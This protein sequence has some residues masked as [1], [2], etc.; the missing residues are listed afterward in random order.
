MPPKGCGKRIADE[1]SRIADA[2]A[3]AARARAGTKIGFAETLRALHESGAL[4]EGMPRRSVRQ[5]RRDVQTITEAHAKAI[6]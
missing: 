3:P 4:R 6:I 2:I 1:T 5:L